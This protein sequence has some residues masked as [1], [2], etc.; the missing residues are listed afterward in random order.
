MTNV[1]ALL[2]VIVPVY[3]VEQYLEDCVNS[4]IKC[5]YKNLEI[6]LVNDGSTDKSAKICNEFANIDPRIRVIHKEN[7]GLSD[8]RNAALDVFAG[9]YV[10]F[11][12]SDDFVSENC[13]EQNMQYFDNPEVDIVQF[14]YKR[15]LPSGK[16]IDGVS[17]DDNKDV[18]DIHE[19]FKEAFLKLK[20]R[21]YAW[22][23]IYK[24]QVFNDLRYPVGR[25]YED[26]YLLP[27]ILSRPYNI[28]YSSKGYVFYRIRE[29]QITKTNSQHNLES[30]MLA[31]LHII[32]IAQLN[33]FSDI[34]FHRSFA[35]YKLMKLIKKPSSELLHKYEEHMQKPYILYVCCYIMISCLVSIK[36]YMMKTARMI[37]SNIN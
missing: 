28:K 24:R 4:L 21:S 32:E 27:E 36:V 13:Y 3:N 5:S 8:A 22:N 30:Q 11:L 18:T 1:E 35:N 19:K 33:K 26:R 6:I 16:T 37:I 10:T 7:G 15:L 17:V 31:N 29:G 2:S 14:A 9:D 34:V 25:N 23:K 12:D 20:I